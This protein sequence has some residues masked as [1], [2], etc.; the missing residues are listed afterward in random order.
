MPASKC[1]GFNDGTFCIPS[2]TSLTGPPGIGTDA[3]GNPIVNLGR[4]TSSSIGRFNDDQFITTVDKQIGSKD[5]LSGR[6]FFSNNAT[7]N[8]FGNA[9][10]L[11]FAKALPGSNRFIKASWSHVL[12]P[13]VVNEMRFGF[14]RFTFAQAPSEPISLTDIGATRGNSDQFPAAYEL[15]V[16]GGGGFSLGTGSDFP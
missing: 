1:P 2:K 15:I 14:N 6:V 12:S 8:P 16:S 9:A 3:N 4:V 10:T 5:K 11:P 7:L 13:S